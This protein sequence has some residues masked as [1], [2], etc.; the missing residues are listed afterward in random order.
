METIKL[1]VG[2]GDEEERPTMLLVSPLSTTPFRTVKI[3]PRRENCA[4]CGDEGSGGGRIKSLGDEDYVAFCGLETAG[5]QPQKGELGREE[6]AKQLAQ[7]KRRPD[8]L[9][10][11]RSEEEFGIIQLQGATSELIKLT[12]RS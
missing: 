5:Q 10:D 6:T 1:V 12:L 11:V 9:V 8:V 3:R 4:V 2:L 7:A